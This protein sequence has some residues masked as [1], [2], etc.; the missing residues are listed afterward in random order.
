[1]IVSGLY[2]KSGWLLCKDKLLVYDVRCMQISS[3]HGSLRFQGN[4]SIELLM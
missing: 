2:F 3:N 1:M 4:N